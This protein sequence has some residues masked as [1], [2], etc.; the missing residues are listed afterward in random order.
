M[1]TYPQYTLKRHDVY[2]F[3]LPTL[4]TLPLRMPGIMQRRA[5]WRILVL[6]FLCLRTR[7]S[8]ACW[9]QERL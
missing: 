1:L 3:T 2:N 9:V 6:L 8:M 5:R 4:D 7:N